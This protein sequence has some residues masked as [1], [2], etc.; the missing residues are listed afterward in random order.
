[1][2]LSIRRTT[3]QV[4]TVHTDWAVYS[5]IFNESLTQALVYCTGLEEEYDIRYFPASA[6][7]GA[8]AGFLISQLELQS[9]RANHGCVH[10][11]CAGS[12]VVHP[13]WVP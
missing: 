2:K 9:R 12:V 3:N 8:I 6:R 5:V 1:M 4:Y 11:G 10:V 13:Q 7:P